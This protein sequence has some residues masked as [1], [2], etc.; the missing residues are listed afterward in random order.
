MSNFE[1]WIGTGRGLCALVLLL[2]LGAT[3]SRAI[4]VDI[5]NSYSGVVGDTLAVTLDSEDLTGLG[6]LAWET[7]LTWNANQ[8]TLV[9]VT[10]AGTLTGNAGWGPVTWST[11][12]GSAAIAAAGTTPLAGTGALITLHFQ[13]GPSSGTAFPAFASFLFNEGTPA[14]TTSN[15]QISI[16]AAPV[17]TVSPDTAELIPGETR[18]FSVFGG[19]SPYTWSTTDPLVGTISGTGLLNALTPGTLR[20]VAQDLNGVTDSSSTVFVRAMRLTT[21]AVPAPRGATI[22][23]PIDVTELGGL[24]IESYEFEVGF[25]AGALIPTGVVTAGTVHSS[26]GWPAPTFSLFPDR[27]L[28]AA[29]HTIPLSGSGTLLYLEF[30]VPTTGSSFTTLDLRNALFDEQ[31][32]PIQ[33]DASISI[34]TATITVSPETASVITGE[35]RQFTA[36]G[37]PTPP[38]AWSTTDPTVATIDASGLLTGVSGGQCRV[39]AQDALGVVDSSGTIDVYDFR[40]QVPTTAVVQTLLPA[41]A[42]PISIDRD[43]T[44]TPIFGYEITLSFSGN[45]VH[46]LAATDSGSISASWGVP[47]YQVYADSIRIAHAGSTPLTGSGPLLH[48][49]FEPDPGA[50]PGALTTL[51]IRKALFNEGLPRGLRVDGLLRVDDTLTGVDDPSLRA[52]LSLAQNRPNPVRGGS[53]T[54]QFSINESMPEDL[55]L[56]IVD[57]T[58]RLVRRWDLAGISRGP[59]AISWDGRDATGIPVS[60]GVYFYRLAGNGREASRKLVVLR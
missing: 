37:S 39:V 5:Q 8:L 16:L 23:V 18:Q 40:V 2:L 35:T 52:G 26:S 11:S 6:V 13:L 49:Y 38:V 14:A 1:R 9:D 27:I 29:A 43:V 42:I 34:T 53:T 54:I 24:G 22:L 60:S 30:S 33:V 32:V 10:E 46:A 51:T 50:A 3:P 28:V 41:T 20:V 21:V 59:H 48:V 12:S 19:V 25:S 15:G 31:Y 45:V 58:G 36:F 55:D 56:R 47:T 57:S 4:L 17:I 7:D 44:A